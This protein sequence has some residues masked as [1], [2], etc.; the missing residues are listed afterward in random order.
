MPSGNSLYKGPLSIMNGGSASYQD[1]I[2]IMHDESAPYHRARRIVNCG[3][4]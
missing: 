3:T 1:Q 2:H 4:T